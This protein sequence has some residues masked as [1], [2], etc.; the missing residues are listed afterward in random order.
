MEALQG[1]NAAADSDS[2][3]YLTSPASL[4]RAPVGTDRGTAVPDKLCAPEHVEDLANRMD[5]LEGNDGIPDHEQSAA[6]A[7]G[8]HR[9]T[10]LLGKGR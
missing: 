5:L 8:P 3:T 7:K 4:P 10:S 1:E 2:S 6:E 9:A